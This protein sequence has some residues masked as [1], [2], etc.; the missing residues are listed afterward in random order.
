MATTPLDFLL[1]K[2]GPTMT[3]EELAVVLKRKPGGVRVVLAMRTE[4]WA[5]SL[6]S[7][8]IYIGRRVHFPTDAVAELLTGDL[9]RKGTE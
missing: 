4:E 5:I 9:I 8:K 1:Q 2:Y 6:N 3:L 7:R